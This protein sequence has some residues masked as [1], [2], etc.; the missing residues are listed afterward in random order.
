F[1]IE[2]PVFNGELVG[3]KYKAFAIATELNYRP[4]DSWRLYGK[5]GKV[6]GQSNSSTTNGTRGTTDK[7]E[8]AY[9][10]PSY[11]LGLIMFNYNFG[12]FS[13]NNNPNNTA[14]GSVKSIYD[15]PI[16]NANYIM[17]GGAYTT[18]KW[19]FSGAF[20]TAKA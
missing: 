14:A 15:N 2:A 3:I 17:L 13:G 7:W 9:L 19:R 1:G 12:N 11:R 8:M 5:F 16:T 10:H 6:P 18:D 4:N 20:I